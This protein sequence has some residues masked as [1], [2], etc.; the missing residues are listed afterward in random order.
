MLDCLI[1]GD[2]IGLGVA[3]VRPDCAVYATKGV[4][5]A[6]FT[7]NYL[8]AAPGKKLAPRAAGT[9]IISLGA[10]DRDPASASDSL[11]L[12]RTQVAAP[13]VLWLMAAGKP[14]MRDAVRHVAER[15]G[16]RVIDIKPM[17]G[18]DGLHPDGPGYL[19]IAAL[20]RRRTA[21]PA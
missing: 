19:R 18:P 10:N 8:S 13:T 1:L 3:K 14:A 16:D 15:F 2:S 4:T 20:T 12:L 17:A 5:S 11:V 9:V 6:A 21:P 7:V